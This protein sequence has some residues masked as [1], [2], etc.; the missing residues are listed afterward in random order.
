VNDQA[1]CD[2]PLDWRLRDFR[3]RMNCLTLTDIA[4]LAPYK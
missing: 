4:S 3:R 1:H 2:D